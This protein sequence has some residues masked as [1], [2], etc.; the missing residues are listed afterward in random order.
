MAYFAHIN[1]SSRTRQR[2]ANHGSN[3]EE[4]SEFAKNQIE[5]KK[6]KNL[7][8]LNLFLLKKMKKI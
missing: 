3:D 4:L 6:K 8:S 5:E 7:V 2:L 1:T